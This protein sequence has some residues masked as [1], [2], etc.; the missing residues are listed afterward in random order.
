MEEKKEPRNCNCPL[1]YKSSAF[2]RRKKIIPFIRHAVNGK[3]SN[4]KCV[5]ST[6]L[7]TSIHQGWLHLNKDDVISVPRPVYVELGGVFAI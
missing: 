2:R 6:L 3:K 4:I 1:N 5:D 7:C